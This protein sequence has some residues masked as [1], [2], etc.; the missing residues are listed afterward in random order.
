MEPPITSHGHTHARAP[1]VAYGHPK[2]HISLQGT[3]TMLDGRVTPKA[4][5]AGLLVQ[6]WAW[7]RTISPLCS[8]LERSAVQPPAPRFSRPVSS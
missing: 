8:D 7:Q 6:P 3:E 1:I 5:T 4:V 2:E